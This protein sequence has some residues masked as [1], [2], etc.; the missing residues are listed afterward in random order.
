MASLLVSMNFSVEEIAA[1]LLSMPSGERQG[2][3]RAILKNQQQTWQCR[4]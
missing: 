1:V 2:A 4:C 3:S